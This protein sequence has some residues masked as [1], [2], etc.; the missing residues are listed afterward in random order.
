MP[1]TRKKKEDNWMPCR[2]YAGKCAYEFHPAGGGAI[3]LCNLDEPRSA[4][5]A[6]YESLDLKSL[7]EAD[8]FSKLVEDYLSSPQFAQKSPRTQKDYHKYK[9]KL[10]LTFGDMSPKAIA[11][12]HV[13]KFLDDYSATGG[14]VQANRH[15]SAMQVICA[16]GYE[17]GRLAKNPCQ[18]ISKFK[19]KARDIY[20]TDEQYNALL[21]CACPVI[22][23]AIE[24]AYLCMARR[25]D[26]TNLRKDNVRDEG[27]LIRQSKTSVAQLKV[28]GPRL[29]R[30]VGY[31]DTHYSNQND[32]PFIIHSDTS[33]HITDSV[34]R[35]LWIKTCEA[36][37]KEFGIELN[38]HFHDI[39]AKGVSDFQGRQ[40]EKR[41][42]AGH[43][44][45]R[46][47][48]TYDRKPSLVDTVESKKK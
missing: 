44:N 41:E 7:S 30:A 22:Y 32:S 28:W 31:C 40:D 19:E 6:A 17:R 35:K 48:L 16:W 9:K 36:A 29:R 34:F 24:I 21:N 42:A 11:P 39:K 15:K 14:V 8:S 47:T 20:I 2:V 27:L 5:W 38:F 26:V 1:R 37:N 25:A 46:Q 33:S 23:A 13:R 43:T 12:K 10:V 18:G 3:R 45:V 4:V